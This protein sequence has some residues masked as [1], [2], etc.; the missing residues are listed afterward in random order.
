MKLFKRI[1]KLVS[2]KPFKP[3]DRIRCPHCNMIM[4]LVKAR[5][6]NEKIKYLAMYSGIDDNTWL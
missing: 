4:T 6:K 3:G 5:R 2:K 1:R